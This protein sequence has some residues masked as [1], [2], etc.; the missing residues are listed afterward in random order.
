MQII[1]ET[2]NLEDMA[3][4]PKSDVV[5]VNTAALNSTAPRVGVAHLAFAQ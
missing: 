5:S 4:L 1:A 3:A 2:T